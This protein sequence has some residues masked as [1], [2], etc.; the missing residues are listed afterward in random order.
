APIS[1][2]CGIGAQ[3]D[4]ARIARLS[5][6]HDRSMC[7]SDIDCVIRLDRRQQIVETGDSAAAHAFGPRL[8]PGGS[9]VSSG[10]KK[11]GIKFLVGSTRY[12][13]KS[14]SPLS[15]SSTSSMKK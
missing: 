4:S 9:G 5:G 13:S 10:T 15:Y 11:S 14:R 8:T 12:L 2:A 7:F 6:G 1:D 3:Q